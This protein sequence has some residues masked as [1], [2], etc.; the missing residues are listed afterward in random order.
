[1]VTASFAR[2]W[3]IPLVVLAAC[4]VAQAPAAGRQGPELGTFGVDLS[5]MDRS[6]APGDDFY[7]F[8]NGAWE[9]RTEIPADRSRLSSFGVLDDRAKERSKAIVDAVVADASATGDRKKIADCYRAYMDE[10]AIE[11]K[12][13]EPLQPVLASIRAI[14]D[15][16]AL[17]TALGQTLR[18]DVDL[19]NAT[20]WHTDRLFGLWVSQ[21][22][23]KPDVCAPYLVQGG[24]ALPDRDY[25]LDAKMAD[26]KKAYEAHVVAVFGL[27]HIDGAASKAAAIVALETAIAGVHATGEDTN[28]VK[29]GANYWRRSEF[30]QKAPG[31][32]WDAWFAAAGLAQ[33]DE[34]VVWQP[35][36]VTGIAALVGSEPLATWQDYLV[37][38]ALDRASSLLPKAFADEHFAFYGTK[39]N[40][41]P[42]QQE[43]WRRAVAAVDECVGEAVGRLYV[44]RHFSAAT[45][46]HADAMVRDLL[47]AFDRRIAAV[48]WMS[49]A[50]KAR[51]RKKLAGMKVAMG[52][53]EKWR[54]YH[55]LEIRADDALGNAM[56]ASQFDYRRNLAKLGKPADRDEWYMLP[57][58]V[59]ALNIPIEN[60]LIFPA[61]ILE[62]PFFD[63]HADDAVNYGA[64]G[65]VIGHEISHS[66]DSSGALFDE[67]G[68]LADWWTPED[69]AR[70]EA[71]SA[72]L[73]A[74][75][76]A[77]RPFP[78]L[79]VNGKLTLGENI[80]DV[81][82]L[83]TAIDAYHLSQQGRT[84]PTIDGF[85][86]DQRLFLGFAQVWR[87]KSRE[88]SLRNQL[89]T[90][91][92][93]PGNCRAWTVRNQDAWYAAFGV[94]QGQ[95]YLAPAD[96]VKIW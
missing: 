1:M 43:R 73:A 35:A 56:R 4:E 37:F 49:D 44:E 74:Q 18:C 72:R 27:A 63:A 34:V 19:L 76:D 65:A 79:A 32:D 66:F 16:R 10:A 23:A 53:P 95:L 82:G 96:R 55:D 67:Q 51:A 93:A 31:L 42:K 33:Q 22:L 11:R 58:E 84:P 8:V 45:K 20:N 92:H 64:I 21:H 61:A 90:N 46:A 38:H 47:T 14:A 41:T 87:S 17:A 25:Y 75:F 54:D 91:V 59:N 60:R 39:L 5:G 86:G 15:R 7:R 77:Y 13:L 26:L 78:D 88:R 30:A 62:A 68:R 2:R 40:G 89:L 69:F 29:K 80:A 28:D 83:A 94:A 24:L 6:A 81:A 9:T 70:F 52:Y 3:W 48:E 36:A 71:A 12:G 85:T 50:T 57:H